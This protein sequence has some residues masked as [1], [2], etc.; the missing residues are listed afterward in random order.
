M[1]FYYNYAVFRV[2]LLV[3]C[4]R[5]SRC[6]LDELCESPQERNEIFDHK[7]DLWSLRQTNSIGEEL[8]VLLQLCKP[9]SGLE[10]KCNGFYNQTLRSQCVSEICRECGTDSFVCGLFISATKELKAFSLGKRL[11]RVSSEK[12]SRKLPCLCRNEISK[13][14]IKS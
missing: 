5:I 8:H 6:L 14:V 11:S 3:N 1:D 13:W 10:L 12:L 4:L 7:G 9:I 2:L